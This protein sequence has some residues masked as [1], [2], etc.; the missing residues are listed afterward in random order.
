MYNFLIL[1]VDFKRMVGF[2]ESYI[3]FKVGLFNM[4]TYTQTLLLLERPPPPMRVRMYSAPHPLP[5]QML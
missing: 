5:P 3:R 1:H 2:G 4:Y